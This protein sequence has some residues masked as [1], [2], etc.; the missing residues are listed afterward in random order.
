[1]GPGD[2]AH[3]PSLE[4]LFHHADRSQA[5]GL[6]QFHVL[7]LAIAVLVIRARTGD[8]FVGCIANGDVVNFVY[9]S[10]GFCLD[11]HRI[12]RFLYLCHRSS[13]GFLLYRCS[14]HLMQALC[15]IALYMSSVLWGN[16]ADLPGLTKK[17]YGT[18]L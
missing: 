16:F 17:S 10:E 7:A 12:T 14:L 1:M 8:G 15:H 18:I 4:A 9:R 5:I 3:Y 11:G 6:I 13:G 2:G